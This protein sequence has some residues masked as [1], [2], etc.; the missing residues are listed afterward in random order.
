MSAESL[1]VPVVIVQKAK[2]ALYSEN[3]ARWGER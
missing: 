1:E 2:E 3:R